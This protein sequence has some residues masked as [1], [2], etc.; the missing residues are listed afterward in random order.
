LKISVVIPTYNERDQIEDCLRALDFAGEVVVVDGG[1][2]DGT[3][4]RVPTALVSPR[5]LATQ[6]NHG[7]AAATGDVIFFVSADSRAPGGWR[8]AI[9]KTLRSPYVVAGGFTLA[10]A[11]SARAFRVIEWGGNFRSR[12]LK[13]ALPD[14]GLFVKRTAFEAVG[15]MREDSMIPY[16]RL[17][18]DLHREGEF[19]LLPHRMRSSARKWRERGI[20]GTSFSHV[21]TYLRFKR[22]EL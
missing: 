3:R 9:E 14:Q 8:D 12:Y 19:V 18:F 15:G 16:A 17:C 6:C 4:E 21:R 10:L 13:I 20:F 22:R 11:D 2:T 7:V 5:G 1:S